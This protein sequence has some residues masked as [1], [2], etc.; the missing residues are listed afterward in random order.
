[1]FGD[2]E[3][4][5][6]AKYQDQHLKKKLT[7]LLADC[8]DVPPASAELTAETIMELFMIESMSEQYDHNTLERNDAE[9]LA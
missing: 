7:A 4:L 3:C 6:P 9:H 1:M 5:W 2:K 8:F